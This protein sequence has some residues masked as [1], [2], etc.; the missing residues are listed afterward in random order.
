M[1]VNRFLVG[2]ILVLLVMCIILSGL[3]L[4]DA[5]LKKNNTEDTAVAVPTTEPVNTDAVTEATP[6]T[7]EPDP[8]VTTIT[9]ALYPALPDLNMAQNTLAQMWAEMEPDVELEFVYWDCYDDPYP[10]G[11]D[12][13]V[14]DAVFLNYLVENFLIYPL[15]PNGLADTT[16]ILSFT[17]EGARYDGDLYG[18]PVLACSNYLIHYTE[19]EEMMQVENF[20]QLYELLS[21]RKSWYSSDG[22][23]INVSDFGSSFYLDAL[24]D[25]TGTYTTYD[26]LNALYPPV[27]D[28]V[29]QLHA[30]N[31]LIPEPA[32]YIRG[33]SYTTRFARGEGSACYS[34]SESL[35]DMKDILD[36][37]TIRPI[38]FFDGEN[39]PMY[40]TDI[41]SIGSHVMDPDKYDLCMKLVNL[42]GSVEYQ[43]ELCFGNG[44]VQYLLPAR[45]QVYLA[46]MEQYPMYGRLYELV[47]DEDNRISRFSKDVYTYYGKDSYNWE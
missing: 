40:Y 4:K 7:T 5:L 21:L 23:Q 35:Y 30:I 12:V 2:C 37:L 3:L 31:T 36:Q 44:D 8:G 9:V 46:A 28:V 42:L 47:M 15:D 26:D 33:R 20:E 39:I 16:G 24:I 11:I 43:A 25:Y 34:F 22:L 10:H 29:E 6:E 27:S 45:E 19:D 32:D 18:L 13:I 14:Y 17:M 38:S 41:A 1:K